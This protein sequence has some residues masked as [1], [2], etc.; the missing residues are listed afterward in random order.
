MGVLWRKL[1]RDLWQTKTRTALVV[2][3]TA[4]GLIAVGLSLGLAETM[5]TR[6]TASHRASHPPHLMFWAQD[7]GFNTSICQAIESLP[8]VRTCQTSG[9]FTIRWKRPGDPYW[10]SGS[11]QTIRNVRYQR[12]H[13]VTLLDGAWPKRHTVAVERQT[14]RYLHLKSGTTILVEVNGRPRPVPITGVVR[15]PLVFPP[16][17]GGT[18]TFVASPHVAAWLTGAKK[19][20]V[21]TV[22]LTQFERERARRVGD[23]IKNRLQRSGIQI[24][25]PWILDPNRHFIQDQVDT[26][27]RILLILSALS[28]GLSVF[29]IINTM[30]A[31][32][33]Q[34]MW[35]IGVLKVLG[36][37]RRHILFHYLSVA[38]IYGVMAALVAVPLAAVGT[39]LLAAYLLDFI[40]ISTGPFVV[41]PRV[42]LIQVLTGIMVPILGALLPVLGGI[43]ITVQESLRTRGI[44]GHFGKGWFDRVLVHI[45][46]LSRPILLSLRNT[47]RRKVRI[48]L[49]L[50]ALTFGGV[51]FIMV[52]TVGNSLN[53]TLDDVLR[54][55]GGD[56][57]VVTAS[58]YRV[59]RLVTLVQQDPAVAYAE[60]WRRVPATLLA[61]NGEK[62]RIGL[63]GMPVPSR[64][65]GARVVAGRALLPGEGRAIL[66]N[67]KIARDGEIQVGDQVTIVMGGREVSWTVVGLVYSVQNNHMESFVSLDALG[68]A[69][70]SVGRGERVYVSLKD[71]TRASAPDVAQRLRQRYENAGIQ[72]LSAG[73]AQDARQAGRNQFNILVYTLLVM[74]VLAA[75]VGSVGL[76]GTLSINVV[77]RQREIGVLRAIGAHN[78]A[79]MGIFVA[80]GVV[81]GLC[82]WLLAIPIS[83][84]LSWGFTQ[85]VGSMMSM[86]LSFHYSGRAL[87]MWLGLVT[88]IS[89]LASLVPAWQAARVSVRESLAY[90]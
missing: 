44:G 36:A 90:E 51:I 59:E 17:F 50:L 88:L 65:F 46:F 68:R 80:E 15:D 22:Q 41:R 64:I 9:E 30:N 42:M 7:K 38:V 33:V 13:I 57:W 40:N 82:S 62:K 32:I 77:E 16:Q 45:R 55:Y 24:A 67:E 72:V 2:L 81:V 69:L 73:T 86:P 49:T 19:D 60:V 43:R 79:L 58:P 23:T 83:V 4:V 3:S 12:M 20:Y 61:P 87:L 70:G 18:P 74:S 31:I 1:W 5:I 84:P 10:R 48:T 39:H 37:R 89:A 52:T 14:A 6:M 71:E 63:R 75:V 8:D 11:L 25:G 54:E 34:Q 21:L 35:Q 85:A 28:L 78:R 66:L 26:L 56:V 47:F 27:M 76:M 53:Q 29:L